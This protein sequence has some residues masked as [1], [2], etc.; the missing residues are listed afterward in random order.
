MVPV[1]LFHSERQV[2]FICTGG[3]IKKKVED[4]IKKLKRE[5]KAKSKRGVILTAYICQNKI[6]NFFHYNCQQAR[7]RTRLNTEC[8][9]AQRIGVCAKKHV[10][11]L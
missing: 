10:K 1:H 9:R 3:E 5:L 4:S 7:N 8:K 6:N 2:Y 11:P